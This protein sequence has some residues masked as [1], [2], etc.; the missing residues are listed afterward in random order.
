M[1]RFVPKLCAAWCPWPFDLKMLQW[2]TFSICDSDNTSKFARPS[3]HTWGHMGNWSPNL[4]LPLANYCV[5]L[6]QN[7][8]ICEQREVFCGLQNTPKCVSGQGSTRTPW[9][10]NDFPQPFNRLGSGHPHTTP[11]PAPRFSRLRRSQLG[12]SVCGGK[13]SPVPLETRLYHCD[14]EWNKI[15]SHLL[16]IV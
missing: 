10:A 16:P 2:A 5:L 8:S 3:D 7:I 11:H 13:L 14:Q 9:G 4:D 15:C 6:T 1:V 12:L